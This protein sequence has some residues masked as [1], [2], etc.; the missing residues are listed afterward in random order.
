M[1]VQLIITY[2]ITA[3]ETYAKYNPGSLEGIVQTLTKHGGGN[4]GGREGQRVSDR[5]GQGHDYC[6]A[7]LRCRCRQSLARGSGIPAL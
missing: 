6:A 5:R 2:D 7:F 4:R 3:P 1:A